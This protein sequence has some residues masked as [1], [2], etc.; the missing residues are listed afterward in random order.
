MFDD[1]DYDEKKTM[2]ILDEWFISFIY[3][4]L[5]SSSSFEIREWKNISFIINI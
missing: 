2:S 3:E 1:D 5:L 4:V